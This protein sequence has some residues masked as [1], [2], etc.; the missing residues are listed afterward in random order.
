LSS[1]SQNFSL[2]AIYRQAISDSLL[3]A[4]CRLGDCRFFRLPINGMPF[5]GM[6]IDGMPINGMPILVY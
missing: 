4:D 2:C 1:T 3:T 5:D 6:P